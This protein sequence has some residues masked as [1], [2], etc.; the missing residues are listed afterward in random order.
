MVSCVGRLSVD[1]LHNRD[2]VAGFFAEEMELEEVRSGY[3]D[4]AKK[5]KVQKQ[6]PQASYDVKDGNASK[7]KPQG[8]VLH[9]HLGCILPKVPRCCG[10]GPGKLKS[11]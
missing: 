2:I 6:P 8:F 3:S 1:R 4:E 7:G 9:L 10:Q 5:K 11:R